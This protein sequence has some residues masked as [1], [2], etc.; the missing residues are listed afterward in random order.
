M[1]ANEA[2]TC[3]QS[4]ATW[5]SSVTFAQHPV[6]Y[7]GWTYTIRNNQWGYGGIYGKDAVSTIWATSPGGAWGVCA[8][9]DG[10]WPYP[11]QQ[12]VFSKAIPINS[13]ATLT[14]TYAETL[15]SSGKWE[16][17]YDIWLNGKALIPQTVELMIW[18][19]NHGES[20]GNKSYGYIT[21]GAQKYELT[22]ATGKTRRI[23]MV[24]ATNKNT[25]TVQVLDLIKALEL[26]AHTKAL[27]TSMPKLYEIDWGWEVHDT[28][29]V[30]LPFTTN[31]YSVTITKK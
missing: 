20:T 25:A 22:V 12:L 24:F 27:I 6:K 4:N 19:Y 13:L 16:S 2:N 5:S 8:L 29:K 28:A 14:S 23:S 15:P 31:K 18:T 10:S 21:V 9:E 30:T 7:G 1:A 11:D 3:P 26:N 17:A